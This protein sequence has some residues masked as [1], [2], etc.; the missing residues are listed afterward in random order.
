MLL[1]L[2]LKVAHHHYVQLRPLRMGIALG[3][4]ALCAPQTG[5]SCG[6]NGLQTRYG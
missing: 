1:I 4:V 6:R 3:R 5:R 2:K